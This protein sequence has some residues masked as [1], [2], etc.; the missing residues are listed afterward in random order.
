M[1][2]SSF[3]HAFCAV[4]TQI[5]LSIIA[6]VRSIKF[7]RLQGGE[8]FR[9]PGGLYVQTVGVAPIWIPGIK[10]PHEFF[11]VEDVVETEPEHDKWRTKHI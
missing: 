11:V 2:H 1:L 4:K 10:H 8:K 5:L 9:G 6:M 3:L 7:L